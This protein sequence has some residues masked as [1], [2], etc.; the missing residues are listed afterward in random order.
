MKFLRWLSFGK[1]SSSSPATEPVVTPSPES[2]TAPVQAGEEI[3]VYGTNNATRCVK[4]RDLLDM[5]GYTYG[6]SG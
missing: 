1:T 5:H 4:V 3:V 6:I 2:G